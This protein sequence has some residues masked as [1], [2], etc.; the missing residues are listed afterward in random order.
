[1]SD[2]GTSR[3]IKT[4][5]F[6]DL[7]S[8]TGTRLEIGDAVA[9]EWT[10]THIRLA[11]QA[12]REF[13]G[14]F[15]QQTGDG[16]LVAFDWASDAL[17]AAER[18]QQLFAYFNDVARGLPSMSVRIGVSAGE[19]TPLDD[20][21]TGISVHEAAR[22]TDAAKGGEILCTAIVAALAGPEFD[23][24]E[25]G[26]DLLRDFPD[27]VVSRLRW[28]SG[29][30]RPVNPMVDALRVE[31]G[32]VGRREEWKLLDDAW[33]VAQ[34]GGL[35]LAYIRGAAGVGKTSLAAE[36]ASNVA[37]SGGRVWF[38]R[39]AQDHPPA[40]QVW[41]HAVGSDLGV[42]FFRNAHGSGDDE[43]AYAF[44][45]R[46]E[47]ALDDLTRERPALLILDDLS[48]ADR[49]SLMLLDHLARGR[50]AIRCLILCTYR[51]V[52]IDK[53][54]PFKQLIGG[55]E[56]GRLRIDL[57]GL[58]TS[59]IIELAHRTREGSAA[60]VELAEFVREHTGGNS[61]LVVETLPEVLRQATADGLPDRVPVVRSVRDIVEERL[62][63]GGSEARETLH[64]AAVIG[65]VFGIDLLCGAC[66]L[67]EDVLDEHLAAAIDAGLI[68][69]TDR[70]RPREYEFVHDLFR[71]AVLDMLGPSHAVHARLAATIER[72]SNWVENA[73]Q[74]VRHLTEA[75][76]AEHRRHGIWMARRAAAASPPARAVGL[77]EQARAESS[78]GDTRLAV[79]EDREKVMI[80][81]E[82]GI[83]RKA[84]GFPGGSETI[85]EAGQ[86]AIRRGFDDIV[87][88]AA[89]ASGRGIF[90]RAG[91]VVEARVEILRM[92]LD[93]I[94]ADDRLTRAR[95]VGQ[96]GAEL[97]W[98]E[99][100]A[101]R[102]LTQEAVDL[103]RQ[104]ND[105]RTL[106]R[107]LFADFGSHWNP[108]GLEHRLDIADELKTL[109]DA[110][111]DQPGWAFAAH[112][113]A[114]PTRL[115]AGD[116]IGGRRHLDALTQLN[117]RLGSPEVEAYTRL[118]QSMWAAKIGDIETSEDRARQFTDVFTKIGKKTEADAWNLGLVYP[119][120]WH[121]GRLDE[122][123][124]WFDLGSQAEPGLFVLPA[125]LAAIRASLGNIDG[126]HEALGRVP[127]G[128]YSA[129][130]GVDHLVA[131][132]VLADAE[133]HLRGLQRAEELV[134]QLAP[135]S[136]RFVLNGTTYFGSA[137]R[138]LAIAC[139][140]LGDGARS[141]SLFDAAIE[142]NISQ[143]SPPMACRTMVDWAR[144]LAHRGEPAAQERSV[145]LARRAAAAAEGRWV[146]LREEAEQLLR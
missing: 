35:A 20:S 60:S 46:V 138:S 135:F 117:D 30:D 114:L 122:L 26:S 7:V 124:I 76:T 33:Q 28:G 22:V 141:D 37:L 140:V 100:A 64:H 96:L 54:E 10:A 74:L 120:H 136:D 39:C 58:S 101:A 29:A 42:D 6:T 32:L 111:P 24:T 78:P 144:Q 4:I 106:V 110:H 113:F 63:A 31:G 112:S 34:H 72:S 66:E 8:S 1:M 49:A 67:E 84:A 92:A 123:E 2:A 3:S 15:L 129:N 51:D 57:S 13:G 126:A 47:S 52:E 95:L 48:W 5:L 55:L 16:V 145:E 41:E 81:L 139:S 9:N 125:A 87:V 121:A 59:E 27:T 40:Y 44:Y 115:E 89:L 132:S 23:L 62:P 90:N 38:G 91:A 50:T 97:T 94:S 79:V 119:F 43:S 109:V 142:E 73:S 19:V 108:A 21:Y 25:V 131:L 53:S 69:P 86:E 93:R 133:S 130:M 61:L 85:V 118:W 134:A 99:P 18:M 11:R 14:E 75:G 107:V 143:E 80:E 98:A 56:R 77:L 70:S 71:E 128:Q 68:R 146:G 137:K 102:E 127:R 83:A 36:I 105:P 65:R 12:T 88:R 103:A 82:L 17:R 104:E 116:I 45:L